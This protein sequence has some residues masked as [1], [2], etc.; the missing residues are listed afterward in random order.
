MAR[1]AGSRRNTRNSAVLP[2]EKWRRRPD[3]NRGWRFCR[4]RRVAL[5]Y[6]WS[7]FLAR[8][9]SRFYVVFGRFCSRLVLEF[10][11]EAEFAR[12]PAAFAMWQSAGRQIGVCQGLFEVS[13]Q[14]PSSAA[15]RGPVSYDLP[16]TDNGGGRLLQRRFGACSREMGPNAALA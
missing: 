5:L 11:P 8:G 6:G 10:R 15:A 1:E 16:D 9:A 12:S 14:R 4:C 3:L 13:G 7:C 2:E